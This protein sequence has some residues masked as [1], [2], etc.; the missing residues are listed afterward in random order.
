MRDPMATPASSAAEPRAE[1]AA[2]KAETCAS[3]EITMP[4]PT[5]PLSKVTLYCMATALVG[6]LLPRGQLRRRYVQS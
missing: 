1:S 4:K 6:N 2:T 5:G 3:G